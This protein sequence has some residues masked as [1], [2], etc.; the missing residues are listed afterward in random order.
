MLS[1]SSPNGKIVWLQYI[2]IDAGLN[3]PVASELDNSMALWGHKNKINFMSETHRW[4]LKTTFFSYIFWCFDLL[5]LKKKDWKL[6]KCT[7]CL[8]CSALIFDF[9]F[10]SLSLFHSHSLLCR[11][12]SMILPLFCVPI[13]KG[14]FINYIQLKYFYFMIELNPFD[15]IM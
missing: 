8:L 1:Q 4:H 13:P 3:P 5:F 9:Q 6:F 2:E 10:S 7:H 15:F 14:A 11:Y 12:L